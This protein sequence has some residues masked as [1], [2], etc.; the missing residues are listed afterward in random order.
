MADVL[1][2]APTEE[3]DFVV[4]G[5]GSAGCVLA[6]RLSADG[7]HQVVVLEAG[8]ADSHPLVRMPLGFMKALERPQLTW[9]LESEPEPFMDQRRVALPRGRLLGGSSSING[10]FH[11]RGDRLDYDD[12][13]AMGCTG[14]SYADVLP[15]FRRSERS[16]RGESTYH[17]GDGAIH[18]RPIDTRKLMPEPLQQAVRGFG[19][20]VNDDLDGA[21]HDG[22]GRVDVAIDPR[23]RRHGSARAYLRLAMGRPNLRVHTHAVAHR[24]LI[25]NGRAVGV[26]FVQRGVRRVVKARREVV[27]SGGAY[28]SPH[29]LMLSGIGPAAELQ[30]LGVPVVR[31]LPGVGANLAEHPRMPLQYRARE[32]VTFINQLR[33]DRATMSVMRWALTGGGPFASLICSGTVLLKSRPDLDRPDFQLLCNPVRVD[34][35]LWFPGVVKAKEHSFYVTVCQLYPK[36]RG[37]VSLRSA[38]PADKPRVELRLFSDPDDLR[39]MRD[40]IAAARQLYQQAPLRA[41]MDDETLPGQHVQSDAQLDAS[42][43]ALGGITHHPVGTCAMGTGP[44]AVV[45]AQLRVHGVAGLRVA[46]ASVMPTHIGANTNATVV[47]IGEKASDLIL[48]RALPRAELPL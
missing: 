31:D 47:M 33:F 3:A 9:S 11:I 25:E 39:N 10:M 14:W 5:A 15:Y 23:G 29:L 24:I 22:L 43:R 16:W 17:G 35:G 45:D 37:R 42:I 46:D 12:W 4:V 21:H 8:G 40:G 2:E 48:G 32:P 13:E 27:L 18:V 1:R 38:N 44:S 26:E 41:L 30:G 28:H 36:S 6:D 20:R 34:A 19:L 7:T